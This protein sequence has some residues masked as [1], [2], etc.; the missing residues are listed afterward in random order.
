MHNNPL[1]FFVRSAAQN[2][3]IT[4]LHPKNSARNSFS[5]VQ[6]FSCWKEG[7]FEFH[8]VEGVYLINEED[9]SESVK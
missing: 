4:P 5:V 3:T 6:C 1:K 8:Y 2:P 9:A 7:N